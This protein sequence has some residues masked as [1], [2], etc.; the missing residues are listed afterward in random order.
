MSF[1]LRSMVFCEVY[2]LDTECYN[3]SD[4]I[5]H[6]ENVGHSVD[7]ESYLKYSKKLR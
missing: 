3:Y 2:K 4:I 7:A 1:S 5:N 6:W